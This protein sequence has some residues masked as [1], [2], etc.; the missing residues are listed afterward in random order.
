METGLDYF[1]ARYYSNV[2]GRFTSPDE[3]KGGPDELFVLGSGDPEKQALVYVDIT[4]PQSLNKYQYTFNNPLRYVD[5]DGQ[6]PQDGLEARLRHD[7]RR[8]AEGKMSKEE[9][10]ARRKAE[11]AGA[12][13][14][15]AI[16]AG[17]RA[18]AAILALARWAMAN[19]DK[20]HQLAQEAVQLSSGNPAPG[21]SSSTSINLGRKLE[22]LL[23]NATGNAHNIQRSTTMAP[24]L[25]RIGLHD[26]TATRQ[27]LTQHLNQVGEAV[28]QGAGVVQKNGNIVRE[29]LLF[30]S[31]GA[32]KLK[33]IWQKTK[34]EVK[35]ITME[36][37]RGK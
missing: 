26:S 14:G 13:V 32:V 37:L 6:A 21:P 34:D 29:S 28:A 20:A 5:P 24:E 19:P 2:Q 11:G 25:G 4:N 36:V 10:I 33:T 18:P 27:Y 15:L 17:V 8:L 7:E 31:G 30:G 9:F 1:L 3:F 35:L 12:L 16:L 22:Y 23:G